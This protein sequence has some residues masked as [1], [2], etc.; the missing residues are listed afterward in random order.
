MR[1]ANHAAMVEALEALP[2]ALTD[3][4]LGTF[5]LAVISTY[6]KRGPK[7]VNFL[8]LVASAA[9]EAGASVEAQEAIQRMIA[10]AGRSG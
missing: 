8:M 4:E 9:E 2:D 1:E 10:Q 6:G 3:S 7:A 5:V